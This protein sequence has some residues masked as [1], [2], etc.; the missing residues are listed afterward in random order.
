MV[1]VRNAVLLA[2][3]GLFLAACASTPRT[4]SAPP[5]PSSSVAVDQDYVDAVHRATRKAGIRVVWVNP[6]LENDGDD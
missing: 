6:P 2:T 1:T 4:A 5:A 3:A